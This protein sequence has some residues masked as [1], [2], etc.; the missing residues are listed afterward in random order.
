[1]Q[2]HLNDPITSSAIAQLIL[3][4]CLHQSE[5][6]KS[7]VTGQEL[8]TLNS[9]MNE[10]HDTLGGGAG[11]PP[12][13]PPP[14]GGRIPPL[15]HQ[16]Q[17][18]QTN[19]LQAQ[20]TETQ[21]SLTSHI[22][23]MKALEGLMGEHEQ[24]KREVGELRDQVECTRRDSHA[25][26]KAVDEVDEERMRG[27]VSPVAAMLELQERQ[28]AEA[29]EDDDDDTR[30]MASADTVTWITNSLQK[31]HL[32]PNGISAPNAMATTVDA[33]QLESLLEQNQKL[34]ERIDVISAHVEDTLKVGSSLMEQHRESTETISQLKYEIQHL[35]HQQEQQR[36]H[37]ESFQSLEQSIL[38][39]AE[40]KWTSW[41]EVIETGWRQQ[42]ETWE[43]ERQKLLKVIQEWE[44]K[45]ALDRESASDED[46][47]LA[48][49]SSSTSVGAS[50]FS[51]PS[52]MK[53][54]RKKKI[55]NA[56]EM[57]VESSAST[58]SLI[59]PNRSPQK[60]KKQTDLQGLD[61]SPAR[62][63][64]AMTR[65]MEEHSDASD[66]TMTRAK[67][68]TTQT[69]PTDRTTSQESE[70]GP[71]FGVKAGREK[72]GGGAGRSMID[73]R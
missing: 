14:Y 18:H 47:L 66:A 62:H 3:F 24:L 41:K 50:P 51:T 44:E 22:E 29:G 64:S 71:D 37:Y 61:G 49:A 42:Q 45:S 8:S 9:A 35:K 23:K 5:L 4:L 15:N 11:P 12:P 55:S 73:V 6:E 63:L 21:A 43:V 33:S 65:T 52:K 60:V 72:E 32:K 48:R 2:S 40:S 57:L 38:E 20:L 68:A 54:S 10:I 31:T 58:H 16:P 26:L 46:E 67:S 70:R 36:Q 19:A 56:K 1:M 30:S 34:T 53:K 69:S 13:L 25:G 7:R 59:S 39:K 27:R 28:Q 17:I